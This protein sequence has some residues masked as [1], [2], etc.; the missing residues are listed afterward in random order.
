MDEFRPSLYI[1]LSNYRL[2]YQGQT[3]GATKWQE[4]TMQHHQNA[5][6]TRG[7][8]DTE[9]ERDGCDIRRSRTLQVR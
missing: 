6:G 2:I 3:M 4:R 1:F 7:I 8:K 5:S 9:L